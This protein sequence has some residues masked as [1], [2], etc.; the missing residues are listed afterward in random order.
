MYTTVET[1]HVAG[2]ILF[3]QSLSGREYLVIRSAHTPAQIGPKNFVPEFWE[4]PK[5]RLEHGEWGMDGARREVK[6]ETGIAEMEFMP[7]FAQNFTYT[8]YRKGAGVPKQVTLYLAQAP[9][10]SDVQISAEHGG[11]AWL[12]LDDALRRITLPQVQGALRAA[13]IYLERM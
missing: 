2:T 8:T 11:Y 12:F 6:E 3:R 7:D 9:V 13:A 5:G 1:E 4:F 10:D